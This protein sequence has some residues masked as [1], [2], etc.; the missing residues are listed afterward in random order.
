MSKYF[1]QGENMRHLKIVS[2]LKLSSIYSF[3][4]YSSLKSPYKFCQAS[5]VGPRG[6]QV[7]PAR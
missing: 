6:A 3:C 1:T 2:L 5:P 7:G 4:T